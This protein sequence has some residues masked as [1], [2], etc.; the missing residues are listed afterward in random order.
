M[1]RFT[2]R[3]GVIVVSLLAASCGGGSDPVATAA[4]GICA[5][6]DAEPDDLAAFEGYELAVARERR[7]GLD[8]QE[9]LVAVEERCGR[10]VAAI[11]PVDAEPALP[12]EEAE[13]DDSGPVDPERDDP[14]PVDL[15]EVDWSARPWATS[16]AVDDDLDFP[17]DP[18]EVVLEP[19]DV[20]DGFAWGYAHPETPV[21]WFSVD[22]D[23]MLR[24]DVTGDGDDDA[25]FRAE[26]IPGN[27]AQPML[28][29][30]T[31][32]DGQLVQLPEIRMGSDRAVVLDGYEVVEGA[33]RTETREPAPGTPPSDG[34]LIEVTTDWTF[35]GDAW[36]SQERSR[37]DTRPP[38]D[39]PSAALPGCE[40]PNAS[41]RDAALCLVAAA[42]A[43]HYELAATVA[44]PSVVE[45]VRE[46]RGWGP[47]EWEFNGCSETCWFYSPSSDPQ[48]HGV[49]IEMGI[50]TRDDGTII[51]WIEA[52]G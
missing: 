28:V 6:I 10:S 44:S 32:E 41:A 22:L 27:T 13:R 39:P 9:L 1:G 7:G 25:L 15:G 31:I 43:E 23:A 19:T 2:R 48:Y 17:D 3:V 37:V 51:E 30:W 34:Y 35:D 49:G 42:N 50:G 16:C 18:V 5:A 40:N 12:S 47:I 24:A 4:D 46:T 8:E 38:P 11:S 45:F 14:D 20:T 52:Y 36:S 21:P 33:I 29:G 26:C